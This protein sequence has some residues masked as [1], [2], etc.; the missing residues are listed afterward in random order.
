MSKYDASAIQVLEGL[1]AVR[2]RPGMY[3]GDTGKN[4]FHHLLW[5]ILDNAVDEA[6]AGHADIITVGLEGNRATV[7]DNGRGMPTGMHPKMKKSAVDVIFTVLHSGGK[8]GGGAY[9]VAGGLHGVGA[10]VVNALSSGLEVTVWRAGES[11]KRKYSKGAPKGRVEKKK[12]GRGFKRKTGTIVQFTPDAEIFGNLEFDLDTIRERLR[13]KAYLTP[14]VKFLLKRMSGIVTEETLEEFCFEKGLLDYLAHVLGECDDDLVTEFPLTIVSEEPRVQVALTWTY[15]PREQVVSF[16]NGIPTQ[17]GGA[18]ARGLKEA[19]V[20]AMRKYMKDNPQVPKRLKILPEDIREGLLSFVSVFVEEPQFQ[21]QT[22]DRLNNPEAKKLVADLV[23]AEML[24]WMRENSAQ[25]RALVLRIVQAAKARQA[26]RDAAAAVKRKNVMSSLRLPGKLADC[27]SRNP[28]ECEIFLVEGDSAG[29]SAK[30]GRDR[31]TQAILPLRGKVLNTE[32]ITLK[33][34]L[35]NEELRNIV[36]ALGCGIGSDVDVAKMRYD[37]VV[38]LMDADTDGHHIAVLLLT[39]FYRFMPQV[40]AAGKVF[41]AQPPLYRVCS[42]KDSYWAL[43]DSELGDIVASL[44][45][46]AKPEITRFKGLGEMPPKVLYATTL[47]PEKRRLLQ[48]GIPDGCSVMT[49]ATI[50]SLMGKDAS[51]RHSLVMSA[52]TR[53]L[54]LDI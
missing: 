8:F 25:S 22:K 17:D 28:D 24:R 44:G 33:R 4:G 37:R 29:G 38:L 30:Q 9:K 26:S 1:E 39:F 32:S 40:L 53:D 19:V 47:D 27:S 7:I 14:G 13:V 5:E 16:A 10:S 23:R 42:G 45:R 36:E 20:S 41:L 3:I 6:I 54:D 52:D 11:W 49:E 46:R 43:D 18:H 35:D 2:K 48:V 21:G 51:T 31:R 50:S 12:L 15:A 34:V